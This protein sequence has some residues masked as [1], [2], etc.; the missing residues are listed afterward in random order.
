VRTIKDLSPC[1]HCWSYQPDM[2]GTMRLWWHIGVSFA[3]A[4]WLGPLILVYEGF[5]RW[6]AIGGT[7]ILAIGIIKAHC[8]IRLRH[9]KGLKGHLKRQ[10]ILDEVRVVSGSARDQSKWRNPESL[11]AG[12][13]LQISV[14]LAIA[15]LALFGASDALL[16]IT[17]WP[18][19]RAWHP[20]VAGPGDS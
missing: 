19:N 3:T 9:P 2:I 12:A 17:G 14:V 18:T 20:E 7:S 16:W 1:P 4:A 13:V 8:W 6:L 5:P 11:R 15:S 10:M